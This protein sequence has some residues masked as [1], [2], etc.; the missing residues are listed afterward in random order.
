M[1]AIITSCWMEAKISFT[2][3]FL[4]IFIYSLAIFF[5]KFTDFPFQAETVES[6]TPVSE[7]SMI[8]VSCCI[9]L[10]VFCRS[11]F[12]DL[13]DREY[14]NQHPLNYQQHFI[15]KCIYISLVFVVIS[16]IDFVIPLIRNIYYSSSLVTYSFS[17]LLDSL[18]FDLSSGL[19]MAGLL[20]FASLFRPFHY[21]LLIILVSAIFYLGETW[22]S[23]KPLLPAFSIKPTSPLPY[24]FFVPIYWLL[25][26]IIF[27]QRMVLA[28]KK[29]TSLIIKKLA[30][31]KK[32]HISKWIPIAI[33]AT[34]VMIIF[35]T[36]SEQIDVETS[37]FES[38]RA[39]L[40]QS[41]YRI[42]NQ[43]SLNS[44]YF[45]FKFQKHNQWIFEELSNYADSEWKSLHKEFSIPFNEEDIYM[46][47]VFIKA[48]Q[49][50]QLGS[51]RGSFVILNADAI[52]ASA[53][54][55]QTLKKTFRH[56]LA[57][58]LINQLSQYQFSIRTDILG[59]FLHEGLATLVEHN[60]N[61]NDENS[62]KEAALHF[63]TFDQTLFEILPKSGYFSQYDYRLNYTLGYVFWG[64]FVKLYGQQK[65]QYF[66]STLGSYDE[67]ENQF[68]GISFL[69]H[70]ANLANIDLYKVFHKSR[71]TLESSYTKLDTPIATD[72]K[73]LKDF[74]AARLDKDKLLIPYQFINPANV[75][76]LFRKKE[77][78]D[79]ENQPLQEKDYSGRKG[80][81]CKIPQETADE[82]QLIIRFKNQINFY[83]PWIDVP[84][85]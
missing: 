72:T 50:H 43:T 20:L 61:P 54:K 74:K 46:I 69:F 34:L 57:H 7:L 38:A 79:I 27:N 16:L 4:L 67:E 55:K 66:L 59:G 2:R 13:D 24:L 53:N 5:E 19:Y 28:P 26:M 25:G 11:I 33:T 44:E 81:L 40:A 9:F 68:S 52:N 14:Y 58:V 85:S 77:S 36:A 75:Y 62:I 32:I 21:A 70:K 37:P 51:T 78:L 63:K 15:G 84:E 6:F 80:G 3:D 83:S 17:N 35:R 48:S 64:E 39:E 76:C 23:I 56:E 18:I 1:K 29:K 82:V 41:V 31:L 12:R 65:V 60:W 47:D 30:W 42:K 73:Q 10:A 8:L 49:Q 22:P 45:S 71:M